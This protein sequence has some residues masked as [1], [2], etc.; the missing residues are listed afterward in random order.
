MDVVSCALNGGEEYE[1]LFSLNPLDYEKIKEKKFDISP[2]GFSTKKN[3]KILV[4]ND[5][6]EIDLN[7]DGWNHFT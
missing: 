7:S 2:I 4:L 5:E 6:N 3:E 1:L